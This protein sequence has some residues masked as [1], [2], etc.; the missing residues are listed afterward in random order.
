MK[1]HQ[2]K[3]IALVLLGSF[4]LSSCSVQYR[5]RRRARRHPAVTERVIIHN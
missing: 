5:E 1:K 2:T 3:I 4:A